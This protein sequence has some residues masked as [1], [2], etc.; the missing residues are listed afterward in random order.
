MLF[1]YKTQNSIRFL[2]NCSTLTR[3]ILLFCRSRFIL[4]SNA[5]PV[6]PPSDANIPDSVSDSFL[7]FVPS[8]ERTDAAQSTVP[9]IDVQEVTPN[10]SVP[11]VGVGI[12]HK[13]SF[14]NAGFVEP[15]V[16]TL[17][18]GKMLSGGV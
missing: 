6:D 7:E 1:L 17:N 4:P 5:L 11:L 16:F 2:K 3:Y 15:K 10:P 14:T 13:G 8:D 9:F 18:V 12:I